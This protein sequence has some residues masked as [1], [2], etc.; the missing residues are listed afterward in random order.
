MTEPCA[1]CKESRI[2][3]PFMGMRVCVDCKEKEIKLQKE[4]DEEAESRVAEVNQRMQ[5]EISEI[6]KLSLENAKEID[7]SI[8]VLEQ[9][10]N[11]ETTPLVQVKSIIDNDE[12]IEKKHLALATFISER[13]TQ[14]KEA[15]FT[16][17]EKKVE[18]ANKMRRDQ[19]YLQELAPKLTAEQREKLR[20]ADLSYTPAT[21]KKKKVVKKGER[22]GP[23]RFTKK[24]LDA[25]AKEFGYDPYMIKTLALQKGV[26]LVE[27]ALM[28][29]KKFE[30][31]LK[32]H[33]DSKVGK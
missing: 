6:K 29:K 28:I 27:A 5:D 33:I 31:A 26:D 14:F 10:W 30:S 20:V 17:D 32:E 18:L 3:T 1:I 23:K 12:N 11:A 22:R 24:Q 2:L 15:I 9:I 19:V 7:N 8:E 13:I 16:I 21:P 4:S 25:V